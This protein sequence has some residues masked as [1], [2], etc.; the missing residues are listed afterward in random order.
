MA[1]SINR[2]I[3]IAVSAA[4]I[5]ILL[6]LTSARA[7]TAI[8]GRF[9][10]TCSSFSVDAAVNG[11]TDDGGGVD[12]FRY[13]I[14][15]G[16]GKKLYSEDSVRPINFTRGVVVL[17][18]SYDGDGIVDGPPAANPVKLQII[19]LDSVGNPINVLYTLSY[20][21]KCLPA[22]GAATYNYDF[23]PPATFRARIN[24]N[25]PLLQYPGGPQVGALIGEAGKDYIAVYKSADGLYVSLYVGGND[26]P[27]ISSAAVTVD[28]ANLPV[29]PTRID[30][31]I[32]YNPPTPI[33]GYVTPTP[34]YPYATS[35]PI[36]IIPIITSTP[37][38]GQAPTNI[39][40]QIRTYRLRM[41]A[42][43]TTN[44]AILGLIPLRTY[45][46]VYGKDST[47]RWIKVVYNGNLGW[48]S[49]AY[50]RLSGGTMAQLPV[51]Q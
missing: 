19:D 11:T 51:V 13:L 14:T 21:A 2:Y 20:D 25:S 18:V 30:G 37:N 7:A 29:Q 39:V 43:P 35:T 50:V 48:V 5:V 24:V 45:V 46:P 3:L 23:Q 22:S 26:L 1:K 31:V 8:I 32:V 16:T 27:W 9:Y 34:I 49:T 41:R 10:A 36:V 40:A 47:G 42:L 4:L 6:P 28:L 38:T 44:S 33:P 12:K 15:D 17:Q